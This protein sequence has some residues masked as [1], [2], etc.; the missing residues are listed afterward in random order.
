MLY[1]TQQFFQLIRIHWLLPPDSRPADLRGRLTLMA[2][3]ANGAR[4]R[5][6][7]LTQRCLRLFIERRSA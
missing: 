3:P 4:L 2:D 1:A 6:T 7:E 5:V